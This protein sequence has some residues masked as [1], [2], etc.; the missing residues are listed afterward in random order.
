MDPFSQRPLGRT[1]LTLPQLGFGGAP[2]GNLFAAVGDAEAEATMAAAWAQ[3][4]RYYDTS[5]W[6]GRGLSERRMGSFLLNQPRASLRLSTKV[7]RILTAPADPEA[8]A[9]TER[10]WPEGLKF[11]HHY[12]YSYGGVMR[13]YEDS[14]QRLGMNRIDMLLIHDL[15]LANMGSEALLAAH[16]TQLATGG[17][18]ALTELKAHGL[19]GAIGAGVNRVGTIE[20]FLGLLD[21]DFFLVA[22]P[23]TLAEQPVLDV[24]FPLCQ[25]RGIGIVIGGVFASGI[26]ATGVVPGARYNYHEP[27]PAEAEH[28]SRIAA[29][30]ASHGVPLAAAALQFPLHHPQVASVIPGA[31]QPVQIERNIAAMRHPIPDALWADLKGLGLL[32]ADA[33]TP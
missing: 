4:V 30:C 8:F 11:E 22:L 18:R 3:G 9:R 16:L 23:Y 29:V 13:S 6:Y 17:M 27:S 19:I 20:R 2:L 25:A 5:P 26:L 10:F 28:V 12:D 32:R 14:L 21:L 33:P 15:D 24:E 7:G 31:F 1:A